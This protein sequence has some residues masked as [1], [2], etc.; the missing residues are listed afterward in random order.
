MRI[1]KYIASNSSYS[2]RA[3]DELI[4]D[5]KVSVNGKIVEKLGM[6]IDPDTMALKVNGK[7]LLT[8]PTVK[9]YLALNKPAGYVTTRNDELDRKTVMSLVP[10]IPNIKPVGRLDKDT[11]GL[12]LFSNDGEF[13][14]RY[15]H[16]RF[17]CKKE[18]FA[19]IKGKLE[20]KEADTLEKGIRLEGRKTAPAA[21]KILKRTEYESSLTITIKEGRKRQIRKM[22]AYVMH[23]VKYLKRTKIGKIYLGQLKKGSYRKLTQLEIND[24]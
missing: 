20:D 18:Y 1:N 10:K 14:N 6:E 24:H 7:L 19:I 21:I 12:L 4:K 23:D 5:G 2:R 22:F 11:E 17:E 16:P 15:T 8:K 9:V 3:A 13:I